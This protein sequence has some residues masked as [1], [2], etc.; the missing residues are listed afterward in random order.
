[1]F[2]LAQLISYYT[3]LTGRAPDAATRLT[4]DALATQSQM[5]AMLGAAV[6]AYIDSHWAP[7]PTPPT[8]PDPTPSVPSPATPVVVINASQALKTYYASVTGLGFEQIPAADQ[9]GLDGLITRVGVGSMTLA[10]AQQAVAAMARG[11]TS[12]VNLS[13]QFFTGTTP[14]QAGVAYLLGTSGDNPW[15]L[16]TALYQGVSLETRYIEFAVNLGK[17][18]E[19]KAT[20]AAGYGALSLT[21]ALIKAYAEIF[22]VALSSTKASEMLAARVVVGDL[23]QTRAEILARYGGGDPMDLGTKAALV[24]WLLA[25]AVKADTGPYAKA[26]NAFLADLGP[27][28]LANFHVDLLAVYGPK[29]TV[30]A[31]ATIKLAH[32]QSASTDATSSALRTT[33]QSDVIK[34]ATGL[35]KGRAILTGDGDDQVTVA[36]AMNGKI[37]LG[38]GDSTVTLA[39]IG[40]TG[41]VTFGTGQNTVNLSGVLAIGAVLSAA[42]SNNT[43]RLTSADARVLGD[44]TGF[45]VVV[46]NAPVAADALT[47]VKG[48][49]IIYNQV[50]SDFGAGVKVAITAANHETVVL[51][52]TRYGVVITD[53]TAAG[54]RQMV[55]HL[56]NFTGAATTKVD[57]SAGYAADGGSITLF[58]TAAV[59][60]A[61]Q[62]GK[63]SL[64][65]NSHSTAGMIYAAARTDTE[66]GVLLSPI[67]TLELRGTGK[68]TAQIAESFTHVD[69]SDAGE[70]D[71]TYAVLG[72]VG[73]ETLKTAKA[74]QFIFSSWTSRLSVDLSH[75]A[76]E[77][78]AGPM[79]FVLGAGANTIEVTAAGGRLN[80][81][82]IVDGA[83]VVTA[84]LTGFDK[85]VDHLVLDAVS[86][87][88]LAKAQ[89]A[90][91]GAASL[92]EA[93]QRV[94]AKVAVND[95]AVFTYG[96]DTYVFVQDLRAGLNM[97]DAMSAGDGL[98]KLTGVTS[99]SVVSGAAVGD[100][101]WG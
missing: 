21:D 77:D 91:D 90:A 53:T 2:T 37:V 17:F 47:G 80:N 97:T 24:G 64:F 42:G 86:Q 93:L 46:L 28:G 61:A 22:G 35:D 69:A 14:Y 58:T 68:L 63:V 85:G 87:G 62:S 50:A 78:Y 36:G 13:Y 72:G 74:G 60:H 19:G 65:V 40:A 16:A 71:L 99:L 70:F 81:L 89:E 34:G 15:G 7:P 88:S 26:Q 29:K 98:I 44:V 41:T 55:V 27:D 101:H 6:L 8:T 96:G 45:Q 94:A 92:T 10:D 25:E 11:T 18:G 9:A 75:A 100:I 49:R 66:A 67:H 73:L 83:V 54:A 84:E 56:D 79:T 33:H 30:A 31:G 12:V 1:M 51:K 4:L 5:G 3:D 59:D 48:A 52:D 57:R 43:L 20:F 32:D 76:D 82:A 38:D 95:L 39:D 23:T